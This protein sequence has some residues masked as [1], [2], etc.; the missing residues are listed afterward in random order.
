MSAAPTMMHTR[1]IDSIAAIPASD[2]NAVAGTDY[3]F[4]RYEF[5]LALEA[6]D[7]VCAA[8]GWQPSHLLVE[9]DGRLIAV[10]PLYIKTHSF[11]EYVFDRTW[12]EAYQRHGLGYY[13]KLLSAIPF[14][15]ASGTRLACNQDDAS[16]LTLV[17]ADALR[18]RCA[19]IGAS[20]WHVLFPEASALPLWQ[21][22]DSDVRLGCQYH[23]FNEHYKT[24]DDF[25]AA[26]TAR[27][28]KEL[29]RE[30]RKVAEQRVRLQRF[31]GAQ[32]TEE[33]WQQFYRFYQLTNLK[34]NRHGGYLTPQFFTE[35]QRTM[36]GQMLL[37]M[38]YQ[39]DAGGAEGESAIAGAL[40]FF[41]SD[42][43][44]GRYWGSIHDVEFLHFE[45]CYYQGIEFCIERGLRRFDPGAQGE[46]KIARGFRPVLTYSQHW[47]AHPGFRAAI[48]DFLEEEGAAVRRYQQQACAALPFKNE[49]LAEP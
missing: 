46:H 24:F 36:A 18:Q 31:T 39:E 11:G 23:W 1:F 29:K 25:L 47:I 13:P 26:C 35:L 21:Q 7:S 45:A 22:A 27:R 44:Y 41:S 34:Y 20:G 28:R 17:V 48:Q 16:A 43:L 49:N 40:N 33:I 9:D 30:R 38:A 37:V 15:P 2:W 5:L 19:V 3:P 6:S 10:L 8:R 42:T 32:I 14:T 4:L 12:A